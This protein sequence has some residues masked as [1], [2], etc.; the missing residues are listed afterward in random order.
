VR[1]GRSERKSQ[2]S[3]KRLLI[4]DCLSA[5]LLVYDDM[6]ASLF[7]GRGRFG[8]RARRAIE[9]EMGMERK[10]ERL[11]ASCSSYLE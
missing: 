8:L 11:C 7:W 10:R 9:R 2:K 3:M 5:I 4:F 1:R 6:E